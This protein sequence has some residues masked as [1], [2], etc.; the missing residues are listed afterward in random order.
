MQESED[1]AGKPDGAGGE[2]LLSGS[3]SGVVFRNEETGWS[4]LKVD[5]AGADRAPDGNRSVSLVG[6]AP[7]VWTG[8]EIRAAGRW[9]NHPSRGLRFAARSIECV[10]PTSAA[11]LERYLASA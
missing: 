4:V 6:K 7:T 1:N 3:V 11:G 5:L 10:A 2:E 8:E 9:E